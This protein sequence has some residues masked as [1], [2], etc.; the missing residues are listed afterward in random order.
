M[1]RKHSLCKERKAQSA[2]I[3]AGNPIPPIVFAIRSEME[4]AQVDEGGDKA[5]VD[6]IFE[7]PLRVAQ[8]VVGFKHDKDRT[9][10]INNKF[11]FLSRT[12]R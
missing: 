3:S 8:S 10:V 12:R 4:R 9:H 2:T 5:D 11:E 6:Y 7:I 1:W